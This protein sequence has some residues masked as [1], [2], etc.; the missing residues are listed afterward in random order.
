MA[1]IG[2]IALVV[3]MLNDLLSSFRGGGKLKIAL[4]VFFI[5]FFAALTFNENRYWKNNDVF[6]AHTYEK[7]PHHSRAIFNMAMVYEGKHDYDKA[8]EFYSNAITESSGTEAYIFNGRAMLYVKM[9]DFDKAKLDSETAVRLSPTTA[10]YHNNL[11]GIY[12]SLGMVDKAYIEFCE[13]IKLDPENDL[14]KKNL[15]LIGKRKPE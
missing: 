9:R 15:V 3:D 4:A 8:L 14:A 10:V 1:S 5:A 12:A 6:F 13:A 11:G 2:L 7:S